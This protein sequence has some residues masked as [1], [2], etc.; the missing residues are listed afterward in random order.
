MVRINESRVDYSF[1]QRRERR[2]IG[3]RGLIMLLMLGCAANS[4]PARAAEAADPQAADGLNDFA[5]GQFAEAVQS[6]RQAA[7][8]GSSTA[9]LYLGVMY[10]VGQGVAHNY[11][12]ALDWYRRAGEAGSAPGLFNVGVMYDAGR[13]VPVDRVMAAQWY[14]RAAAAGFGRASYNLAL[15]LQTGDGV[16]RDPGRAITLFRAAYRQGITAS[17]QH[18]AQLGRPVASEVRPVAVADA[19]MQNFEQAQQMMLARGPAKAHAAAELFR[20]AAELHN[21]LAEYDYGYCLEIGLGVPQDRVMAYAWYRRAASDAK[22]P[23]L[24]AIAD[25]GASALEV[26]FSGLQIDDARRALASMP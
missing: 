19:S 24:H 10:D 15:L 22:D 4:T 13:G 7:D 8:A 14:E 16:P 18:L 1:T 23:H 20:R 6:W 21:P 12:E 5:A 9:A 26:Q 25:A 2:P 11:T 3:L 17:R